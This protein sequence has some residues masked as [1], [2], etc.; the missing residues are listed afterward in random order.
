MLAA[1]VRIPT[2]NVAAERIHRF[3]GHV[4]E[5]PFRARVKLVDVRA[6]SLSR[7]RPSVCIVRAC[8]F[9]SMGCGLHVKGKHGKRGSDTNTNV[10]ID[11]PGTARR[12]AVVKCTNQRRRS[13]LKYPAASTGTAV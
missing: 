1:A 3:R 2:R 5:H 11:V 13:A 10:D 7:A 12:G 4:V 9:P 6:L 8:P